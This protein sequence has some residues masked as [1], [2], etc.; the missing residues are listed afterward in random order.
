[1][2]TRLCFTRT[3]GEGAKHAKRDAI[4]C[5]GHLCLARLV[6]GRWSELWLSLVRDNGKHVMGGGGLPR[7]SETVEHNFHKREQ[8]A[9]PKNATES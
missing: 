7:D 6:R 1:M 9:F 4:Q 2:H 5:Q 8:N 3:P